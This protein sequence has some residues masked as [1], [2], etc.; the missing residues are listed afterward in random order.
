M[1]PT[2]TKFKTELQGGRPGRRAEGEARLAEIVQVGAG[3]GRGRGG[4]V[5]ISHARDAEHQHGAHPP[6]I[7]GLNLFL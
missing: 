6:R 4:G 7:Q 2:R 3:D 5:R 1:F